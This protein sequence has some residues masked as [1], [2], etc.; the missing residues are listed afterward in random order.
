[1]GARF[2]FREFTLVPDDEPDAEPIEFAFQCAVCNMVGPTLTDAEKASE[3]SHDHLRDHP[4]H[5]T[6]RQITT[7]P[8]RMQPGEWQ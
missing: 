1:M 2:R 3:W 8:Y 5:F 7:L 6:Y 4:E